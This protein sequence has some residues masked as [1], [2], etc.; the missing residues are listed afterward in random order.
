MEKNNVKPGIKYDLN[1]NEAS[2]D[3]QKIIKR[4]SKLFNIGF[5]RKVEFK[6]MNYVYVFGKPSDDFTLKF[7]IDTEI[8]VIFNKLDVFEKRTLD[9]VDK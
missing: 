4:I 7:K 1:I 8:L 9:I 6:Q 2:L 5:F 3:E